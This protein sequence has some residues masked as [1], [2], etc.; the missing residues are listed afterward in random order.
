MAIPPNDSKSEEYSFIS[1]ISTTI[2]GDYKHMRVN[3]LTGGSFQ[4]IDLSSIKIAEIYNLFFSHG[5]QDR[6]IRFFK[7]VKLPY[8]SEFNQFEDMYRLLKDW[9]IKAEA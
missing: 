3:N 4:E 7:Y 6:N 8:D 2:S 9:Q 5:E 1:N